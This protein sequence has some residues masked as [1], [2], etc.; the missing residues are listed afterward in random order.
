MWLDL[1][2]FLGIAVLACFPVLLLML[3]EYCSRPQRVLR[4]MRKGAKEDRTWFGVGYIQVRRAGRGGL[5][6][7]LL[8]D[9]WEINTAPRMRARW[10]WSTNT[11][12]QCRTYDRY[13]S[14]SGP[15]G[16]ADALSESARRLADKLVQDAI[17]AEMVAK[18]RK[19]NWRWI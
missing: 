13:S 15:T 11:Y 12:T 7:R 17:S 16:E 6:R 8:R 3:T 2:V 18:R 10:R 4:Q 9:V 14:W 5:S 1:Y 19:K